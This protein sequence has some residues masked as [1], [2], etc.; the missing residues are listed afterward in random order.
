L[1]NEAVLQRAKTREAEQMLTL[2]NITLECGDPTCAASGSN[3]FGKSGGRQ[4]D[5]RG[6]RLLLVD[7]P[8]GNSDRA[9][10][11]CLQTRRER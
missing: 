6:T 3:G 8:A 5:G 11:D 9:V 2:G 1:Q 10:E 4:G 7:T